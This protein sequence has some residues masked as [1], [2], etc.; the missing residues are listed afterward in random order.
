MPESGDFIVMK[1][2]PEDGDSSAV[3][4]SIDPDT[5]E[6][7]SE[8]IPED[9]KYYSLTRSGDALFINTLSSETILIADISV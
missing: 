5:K 6:F 3:L 4:Y 9:F 8:N 1:Y 7:I 2:Q